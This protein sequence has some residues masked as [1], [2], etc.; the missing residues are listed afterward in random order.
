LIPP[1]IIDTY[2][3]IIIGNNYVEIWDRDVLKI[4]I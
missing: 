2:V 4:G 1:I 3:V